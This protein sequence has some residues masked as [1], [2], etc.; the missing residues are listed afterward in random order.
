MRLARLLSIRLT[1]PAWALAAELAWHLLGAAWAFTVLAAAIG[2]LAARLPAAMATAAAATAKAAAVENRVD[3]LVPA[4]ND[5]KDAAATAQSSA[6][7]A[8]SAAN[9]AQSTADN[10]LPKSGGYVSGDL[11]IQGTL[12]GTGGWLTCGDYLMVQKS[13]HVDWNIVCDQDTWTNAYHGSATTNNP[14]MGHM[15]GTYVTIANG[16]YM[17]DRINA[18]S[19]ALG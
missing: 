8:Q 10:A 12:W 7:S 11:H 2:W 9:S 1:G 19:S 16:N 13:L 17:I 5:A 15:T 6:N 14:I 4:V 18:L 3:A